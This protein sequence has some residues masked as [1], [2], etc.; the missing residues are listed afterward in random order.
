[1][2]ERSI[3]A[4]LGL[5]TAVIMVILSIFLT[6]TLIFR[7]TEG[8]KDIGP[9]DL[10]VKFLEDGLVMTSSVKT[11]LNNIKIYM[12]R[13]FSEGVYEEMEVVLPEGEF[14]GAMDSYQY[15]YPYND[16]E[17]AVVYFYNLEREGGPGWEPYFLH[18]Y[19]F[20]G[21]E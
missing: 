10:M 16:V 5:A 7:N 15:N 11:E 19:E 20:G 12:K 4:T 14:L 21:E 18:N 8:S 9:T 3:W 17:L 13:R 1:M 2:A 6:S